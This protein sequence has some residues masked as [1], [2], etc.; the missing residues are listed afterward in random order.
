MSS[1]IIVSIIAD[2]IQIVYGD[3]L[4]E[5]SYYITFSDNNNTHGSDIIIGSNPIALE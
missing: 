4:P 2:P 1:S 5:L 3:S